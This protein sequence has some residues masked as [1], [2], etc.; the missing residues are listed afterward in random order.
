MLEVIDNKPI[1]H[2][3]LTSCIVHA[4]AVLYISIFVQPE[5]V[6]WHDLFVKALVWYN[7]EYQ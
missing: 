1:H 7:I 4:S 6:V 2:V 5:I 3:M